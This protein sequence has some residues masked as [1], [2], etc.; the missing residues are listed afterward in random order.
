M[1][2]RCRGATDPR[3]GIGNLCNDGIPSGFTRDLR[4]AVRFFGRIAGTE[5]TSLLL[6]LSTIRPYIS[7]YQQFEMF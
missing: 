5:R 6:L 3:K 4:M 2:I 1:G 7:I